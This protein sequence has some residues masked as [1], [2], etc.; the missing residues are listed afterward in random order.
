MIKYIG[1]SRIDGYPIVRILKDSDIFI[2]YFRDIKGYEIELV[3]DYLNISGVNK[4]ELYIKIILE[5]KKFRE[6]LSVW[7]KNVRLQKLK[8]INE[9]KG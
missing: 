4:Q 5:S 8:Q 7:K 6:E 3:D 2:K 9:Y 1:E